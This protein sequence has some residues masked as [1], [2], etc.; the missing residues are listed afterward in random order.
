VPVYLDLSPLDRLATVIV[1]GS[2]TPRD[3]AELARQ[4]MAPEVRRF[5]KIIDVSSGTAD[6]SADE[7]H[8]LADVLRTGNHVR[9]PIAFVVDPENI[10]FSSVFA[11]ATS[12]DRPVKLFRSLHDARQ[13]LRD[14]RRSNGNGVPAI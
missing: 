1:R 8:A 13:W 7:I 14:L 3:V 12:P 9:G 5:D 6:M 4:L 11:K 10:R 2:L